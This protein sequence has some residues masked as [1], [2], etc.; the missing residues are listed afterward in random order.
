VIAS[1]EAPGDDWKFLDPS[2]PFFRR[3]LTE[4]L[5]D[6][7]IYR[8]AFTT[9]GAEE[10]IDHLVKEHGLY[11]DRKAIP[12]P[13]P[14]PRRLVFAY[15]KAAAAT[16][17]GLVGERQFLDLLR[18]APSR[19]MPRRWADSALGRAEKEWEGDRGHKPN[20]RLRKS[21]VHLGARL[22]RNQ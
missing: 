20:T 19:Q 16:K 3:H 11:L 14:E 12:E 6:G 2:A 4:D 21:S 10:A 17:N 5:G 9:S 22:G 13:G 15:R 1:R 18:T 7:F 8:D